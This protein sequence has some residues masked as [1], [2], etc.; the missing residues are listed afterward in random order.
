MFV[1]VWH[2]GFGICEDDRD[3]RY[4]ELGQFPDVL[5]HLRLATA[6]PVQ[7]LHCFFLVGLVNLGFLCVGIQ[8]PQGLLNVYP[9]SQASAGAYGDDPVT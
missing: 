6:L 9:H 8:I 3:K 1:N 7:L 2:K 4:H 5:Q